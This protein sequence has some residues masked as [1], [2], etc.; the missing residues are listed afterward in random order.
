MQKAKEYQTTNYRS[1]GT[2]V[3]YIIEFDPS[4]GKEI[5]TTHY[6]PDGTISDIINY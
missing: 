3:D 2:T 1:D 5:K 4:T 6:Q